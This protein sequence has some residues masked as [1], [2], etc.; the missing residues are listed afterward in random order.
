MSSANREE[1]LERV[2]ARQELLIRDARLDSGKFVEYALRNEADGSRLCNAYFH[3]EWHALMREHRQVVL[4]APVE[5][6]KSQSISVGK[7][8]HLL[9]ENS[10]RRIALISSSAALAKKP[11][12]QIRSEIE[13]NER[14]Q[15]VFPGLRRSS[16]LEDPWTSEQLT[17][18][19][20][21]I[22][23]DPSL[24][25][26]GAF[27]AIVGSRLDVIILDDVLSFEN[28]RTE[29]QRKKLIEWFDTIVFQRATDGALIFIIGT[30]W[31]PEDL[32]HVLASRPGFHSAVYSAVE[33]P[34]DPP[35]RWRPMWGAQW[36][37]RRLLDRYNNMPLEHFMRKFLCRVRLDALSRF[38]KSWLDRMCQL[39]RGKTFELA[40]PPR[41][42]R[43]GPP[44]PC[45]VGVDLA[46]GKKTSHQAKNAKTVIATIAI[47]PNTR[48]LFANISSGMWQAPEIL[49]RLKE[50]SIT[51]NEPEILVE[52][53]A[54]QEYLIQI[55]EGSIP[56]LHGRDT[57]AQNKYNE[58]W[59]VE[60]LA[61]ELKRQMWVMPSGISGKDV[62]ED[63]QILI[64]QM[65]NY[66]PKMH[67]GDHL[68]AMWLA[69]ECARLWGAV[70]GRSLDTKR[71]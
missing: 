10:N 65:L 32:L 5:H 40:R 64:S 28:T 71:R 17:V 30:P 42:R 19:R 35:K 9:G 66:D 26:V 25:A 54:A 69:R 52:S 58:Q 50:T 37:L 8:L 24:Q 63:G 13:R 51:Y 6:A 60:A 16:R 20:T 36:P 56:N 45:F 70:T 22:A 39:G 29:E 46:V 41:M 2:K 57:Q 49:S 11:L 61:V 27:G 14:V 67:T 48:R 47:M 43:G 15:E 44:L 53:N 23:K 33:N 7:V 59:G 12:K 68:M 4:V 38:Q 62:P 34:D 21:V 1:L 18:E 31:H 3:N 55:G